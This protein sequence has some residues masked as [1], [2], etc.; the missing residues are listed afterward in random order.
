MS[1]NYVAYLRNECMTFPFPHSLAS[2][3]HAPRYRGY[4]VRKTLLERRLAN[5]TRAQKLP[6]FNSKLDEPRSKPM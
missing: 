6:T 3:K 1:E 5:R 2:S 4:L